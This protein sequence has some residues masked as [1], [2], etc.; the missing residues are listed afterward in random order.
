MILPM[1]FLFFYYITKPAPA[2]TE[3]HRICGVKCAKGIVKY[4]IL[5]IIGTES[6]PGATLEIKKQGGIIPMAEKKQHKIVS[7]SSGETVAKPEPKQA[8]EVGNPTPLRIGAV[9]L[10]VAALIFEVLAVLI[11]FGKIHMTFMPMMWQLI[12]MIV[13]DLACVIIGAQ[14]WKKANHIDPVSEKN[15]AKFW[16]W[17]NM[18]V[19]ACVIC[20][21][22]LI[23]I[24]LTN[25]NLD[26]QTKVICTVAAIIALLIGG[27]TS[28]DWNPVSAEQK[29]AAVDVLGSTDVYW[30]PFGKVYH[31]HEDCPSLNRSETLTMGTVEQA[32]AA[33]RVRLCSFCANRDN[34]TGVATEDN[35]SVAVPEAVPEAAP[36]D[37]EIDQE[38]FD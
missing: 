28:Y 12:V 26:K 23:I 6:N 29:E 17:N 36:V 22:P 38:A 14:L 18:G 33:N 2:S 10:W 8:K 31:T 24:M 4:K 37:E 35:G 21:V 11:V 32:I 3:I 30:A 27:V 7:A 15:K 16:L 5:C 19:I 9:L 25:K 1:Y 20:F 34:I 13:L